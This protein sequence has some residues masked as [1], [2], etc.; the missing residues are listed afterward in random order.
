[1]LLRPSTA[2]L[3]RVLHDLGRIVGVLGVGG[4]FPLVW[5]LVVGEITEAGFFLVMI[6]VSSLFAAVTARAAHSERIGLDWSHGLVVTAL[7]WLVAPAVA[8][9]PLF[10]SGHF[11]R[12]LDAYF[13]AMS[14]LTTTGLSV[15][16]DLDHLAVSVNVWRHTLHFL[17]GQG[18]IVAALAVLSSASARSLYVAEGREEQILPSVGS[19]VRFIWFVSLIHAALGVT[20][21]T[22]DAAFFQGF[23]LSRSFFHAVTLFMAAFDTGGFTP[24]S[25]SIAYYHSSIFEI[26]L[27]VLMV[28]GAMSFGLHYAVWQR[29]RGILANI[30]VR[31]IL[32][33]SVLLVSTTLVGLAVNGVF[34]EPWALARRG[35]FQLISA[36]TG[37]GF[38]TITAAELGSWRGL[39]FLSILIAM[40]LGG[41]SSSTA[42][43]VKALRVGLTVRAILDTVRRLLLPERA[44]LDT[45]Y[46]QYGQQ[47]LTSEL[48]QSVMAVSL[49]YVGLYLG[50]AVIGVLVGYPLSDALFESVSASAAVGM[51]VGVTAPGMSSAL[52]TT[53][54]LQMWIGRLEVVSVFALFGFI[55]AWVKGR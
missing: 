6:G 3:R 41:M 10:L 24:Q 17:G 54:I 35:L 1:M 31:T 22:L 13:D 50:G 55:I 19:T 46:F 43:G 38:Q 21:L 23:T 28:A 11:G 16:E 36:H 15:I 52:Q 51:S 44:V 53:M 30:E 2:D 26:T 34:S 39:P 48:A 49:L 20:V 33:T 45:R 12:P 42:G 4:I 18:I 8:A 14:G 9:I 27:L 5:A 25:T 47:R 40:A 29:R 7:T 37:T 32:S